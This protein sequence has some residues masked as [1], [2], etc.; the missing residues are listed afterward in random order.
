MS[1]KETKQKEYGKLET[2]EDLL[3]HLFSSELIKDLQRT[4]QLG[5]VMIA[6]ALVN[7]SLSGVVLDATHTDGGYVDEQE[8]A[9]DHVYILI[10]LGNMLTDYPD[11]ISVVEF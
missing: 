6:K 2:L 7:A 3:W 4:K 5:E 8:L 10:D 9:D 11:G 1:Q